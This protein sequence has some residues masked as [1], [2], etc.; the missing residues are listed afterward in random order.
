[1]DVSVDW[2]GASQ[3]CAKRSEWIKALVINLLSEVLPCKKDGSVG[4]KVSG[5]QLTYGS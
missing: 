5:W 4:R 1:M 2:V 3:P